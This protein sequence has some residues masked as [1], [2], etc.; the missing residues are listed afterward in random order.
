MR[1]D[2]LIKPISPDAPCGP[3]LLEEDDDAFLDYYFNVE[4]RLPTSYYN[5]ARGELFDP[6]TVDHKAETAQIDAL[7]KRSRDIR[8]LGLEAKF[9]ILAGRFKPFVDA[10]LAIAGLMETYPEDVIPRVDG[11]N[12]DR[13]NALE[14]L[15]TLA[16][17]VTPL[18][19][20]T[21]MT[22]RRVGDLVY[23]GFATGSGKATPREDEEPGDAAAVLQALSGSENVK[24]VDTLYEQL[25][26]LQG[27]VAR[28]GAVSRAGANPFTPTLDRLTAKIEELL[29]MVLQARPDLGGGAAEAAPEAAGDAGAAGGAVAAPAGGGMVA[30]APVLPVGAI[31]SHR[32]A[33]DTLER[34]ERYFARF[35]P[36]ALALVLVTQSRL[37]IGR[38]LVEALDVLLENT[39]ERALI[40]FG[41]ETGFSI[42]MSRMRALSGEAGIG[43]I[44]GEEPDAEAEPVEVLSRDQAA[45]SLK[46]VEEFFRMREPASPIPILLFK[47]R[48]MLNKDFHAIVR[49]LL[50]KEDD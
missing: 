36:S 39:S 13:R 12:T 18:D 20:A 4:D 27:A 22:D 7:L 38:P 34:V 28:I 16:T 21:L 23:R 46:L 31:N 32:A 43:D 19:Y 48:N 10:V 47:A 25:T 5:L 45:M 9:Q 40:D 17:V 33:K 26:G 50:P 11:G 3:D 44:D 15:N 14:E 29:D 37:L 30:A 24:A 1:Y 35:E 8:L 41:T 49:E 42:S 2:D 6:R